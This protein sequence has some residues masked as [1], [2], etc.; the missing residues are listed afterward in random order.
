MLL[1]TLRLHWNIQF[2]DLRVDAVL[3]DFKVRDGYGQLEAARTSSA[4]I[5]KQYAVTLV[6]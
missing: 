5:E 2:D 4:W 3:T 1:P 6:H